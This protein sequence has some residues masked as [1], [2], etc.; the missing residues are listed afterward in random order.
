MSFK[1]DQTLLD[2]AERL[3][4]DLSAAP[5]A[6]LKCGADDWPQ[7]SRIQEAG[8]GSLLVPENAGGF[9]GSWVDVQAVMARAGFHALALPLGETIVVHGLLA[10][11]GVTAPDGPS[12]FSCDCSG[13]IFSRPEAGGASFSGDIR[14][15]PWG[16]AVRHVLF[17]LREAHGT[18]CALAEVDSQATI[19]RKTNMAGEP[20]DELR[21]I[22]ARITRVPS[23]AH[24]LF[25]LGALLRVAQMSG[26]LERVLDLSVLHAGNRVQFGRPLAQ[27]QVIQQQ[28]ALMAEEAAAVDCASRAAARAAECGDAGFEIAAAKL[29]AN[30]AV[31]CAA[32]IAHQCHGAIGV[33]MEHALQSFTRRLWAWRA[34]FGNE[35]HWADWLGRFAQKASADGLWSLLT[36]RGDRI[37]GQAG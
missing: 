2:T 20:R 28:L 31:A 3:F 36:A 24:G 9:G 1:V 19:T 15:V 33:T 10:R 22:G 4:V 8:F 23:F 27:F 32:A 25:S 29:R 34:E 18:V 16:R 7:W 21:L 14:G 12:S 35:D 37:A 5:S 30:Q 13:A 6:E 11:A 17:E 26:A